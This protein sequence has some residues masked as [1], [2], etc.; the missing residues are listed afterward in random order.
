MPSCSLCLNDVTKIKN[1]NGRVRCEA[2]MDSEMKRCLECRELKPF[3]E[4]GLR[5]GKCNICIKKYRQNRYAGISDTY[6]SHDARHD[7]KKEFFDKWHD[8]NTEDKCLCGC[9]LKTI[10]GNYVSP[11]VHSKSNRHKYYVMNGCIMPLKSDLLD[12]ACGQSY[13][14]GDRDKHYKSQKHIYFV[15]NNKQYEKPPPKPRSLGD[16]I[17]CECGGRYKKIFQKRHEV[18]NKHRKWATAVGSK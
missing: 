15:E 17:T 18:S 2:C 11:K 13:R 16:S 4:Y 3:S 9:K 7:E 12:C 8:P 1:H 5:Q 14:Y 10:Q 6:K